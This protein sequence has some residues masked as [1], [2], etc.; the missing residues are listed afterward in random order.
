MRGL[1]IA[2]AIALSAL[3]PAAMAEPAAELL[4][5]LPKAV[6]TGLSP[7]FS[8][9]AIGQAGLNGQLQGTPDS[10]FSV[11]KQALVKA[12]YSEQP[13]RTTKAGWG[14]SATW[15]VPAGISVDATPSGKTA[16]LVT[17]ATALGPDRV[18]LNIRF[19]GI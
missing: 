13:I 1:L 4:G 15:A 14:F 6:K 2:A 12:G 10:V 9:N 19:E 5:A 3:S 7:L 11:V 17:Q 18:N 8:G 16:V